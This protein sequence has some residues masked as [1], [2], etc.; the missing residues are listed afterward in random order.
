MQ[1]ERDLEQARPDLILQ[2]AAQVGGVS[3][4][5]KNCEEE[6]GQTSRRFHA[7]AYGLTAWSVSE[8]VAR[9][10]RKLLDKA[11]ELDHAV[12][13]VN[14]YAV[15][16]T[17]IQKRYGVALGEV[18]AAESSYAAQGSA[19][20]LALRAYQAALVLAAD[21]VAAIEADRTAA[22]L[23]G[24]HARLVLAD[25]RMKEAHRVLDAIAAEFDLEALV[26]SRRVSQLDLV[27]AFNS[28]VAT[29]P[30]ALHAD[31]SLA[32]WR[33][34]SQV[35]LFGKDNCPDVGDVRQG[36]VGDC[37]FLT[38]LI[39]L[40]HSRGGRE[41]VLSMI[42]QNPDGT[43]TV[44]FADGDVTV[45]GQLPSSGAINAA[46]GDDEGLW[47]AVMEKAWAK[48]Q[49]S[50]SAIEGGNPAWVLDHVL[51]VPNEMHEM[52]QVSFSD[53]T[54]ALAHHQA[55]T[56]SMD[57]HVIDSGESELSFHALAVTDTRMGSD[58]QRMFQ[59]VNPW[60]S[61]AQ[62]QL[63][64]GKKIDYG[65]TFWVTETDLKSMGAAISY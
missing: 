23:R 28:Y 12:R 17:E 47:V 13:L 8:T 30:E 16:V 29:E 31:G 25:Q 53:L 9:F 56:L 60:H 44:H 26:Y 20:E 64:S 10:G 50:Y 40:V 14:A 65:G 6:A 24:A 45:D 19:H 18:R 41:R 37:Y 57:L 5:L 43:Y 52:T 61:H 22:E 48:H 63:P 42:T 32:K 46:A 33:D 62:G 21:V 2:F 4:V 55:A 54:K 39:A 11:N 36:G 35:R 51:G 58:G 1:A 38:A 15:G 7:A 59:I 3:G 49:G 34:F 27:Y